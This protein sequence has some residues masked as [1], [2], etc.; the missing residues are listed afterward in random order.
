MITSWSRIFT[1]SVIAAFLLI[2]LVLSIWAG[3]FPALW[4]AN[5]K[6]IIPLKKSLLVVVLSALLEAPMFA[7]DSVD[8]WCFGRALRKALWPIYTNMW[9]TSTSLWDSGINFGAHEHRREL[10]WEWQ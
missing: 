6:D 10:G 2:R 4:L 7:G 1:I 8:F 3:P 5:H 9:S